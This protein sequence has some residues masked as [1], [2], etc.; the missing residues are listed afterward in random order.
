MPS[1]L[2]SSASY[3]EIPLEISQ[4]SVVQ[5]PV[6]AI[7]TKSSTM[8]DFP[9]RSLKVTNSGPAAVLVTSVKSG[10]LSPTLMDI[11]VWWLV[12]VAAL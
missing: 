2:A 1:T 6:K 11:V 12:E 4:N 5:P 7:G 8:L 10:A 9:M 3:S